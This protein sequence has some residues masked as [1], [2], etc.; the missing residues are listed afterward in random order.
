MKKQTTLSIMDF[1]NTNETML[2]NTIIQ[3][4]SAAGDP[5][6]VLRTQ[7][8]ADYRKAIK[9]SKLNRK[10]YLPKI[11]VES[12]VEQ[13][14]TCAICFDT[15]KFNNLLK[16]SC[17]HHFC[18][19]CYESWHEIS[20][21]G[22]RSRVRCPNCRRNNPGVK[23]YY[24]KYKPPKKKVEIIVKNKKQKSNLDYQDIDIELRHNK[25]NKNNNYDKIT[26][27]SNSNKKKAHTKGWKAVRIQKEML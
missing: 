25:K 26:K 22:P 10:K 16:T 11:Y 18:Y 6:S 12:Y 17:N 13:K 19:P 3:E 7:S 1:R 24:Q 2:V 14:N 27:K 20:M 21:N 5:P 15:P 4:G 8:I 9:L 23:T